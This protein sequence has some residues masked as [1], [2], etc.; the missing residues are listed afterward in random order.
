[1]LIDEFENILK[2]KPE[3][4][5]LYQR[6]KDIK[7]KTEPL[8]L[9][10]METFPEYTSHD[11]SHSERIFEKLTIIIPNSLIEQLNTYEIYFLA[12]S[13]YFHDIGMINF[14]EFWDLDEIYNPKVTKIQK[15]R[16]SIRENHHL[17]SEDFLIKNFKDFAIEDVHQAKIIGRICRGHRKEDLHDINLYKPD[18]I[19]QKYPINIPLLAAL[20][21]IGDELDITFERT[22]Q[23]IYDKVPIR[24]I[25]SND[26]WEKHL[27]ISGVGLNPDNPLI[28][29]CNANCKNPKIHRALKGLETKINNQ[30]NDLVN[31]LHQY[32]SCRKDIPRTFL[33]DIE[34]ED[35]TPYDFKFSLQEKEIINLLMGEKLY[36]RKEESIRELLKNSVDACRLRKDLFKKSRLPFSPIV[37]FELTIDEN[38]LIVTDNGIGMDKDIIERYFTKI[39]QSFYR[40]Q[41]FLEMGIDFSPVNELG[42]GILSCFMI[43]N[44]IVVETKM[45]DSDPLIIEIDDVSDYF[46]VKKGNKKNTGTT[47]TLFLKENGTKIKL[48]R[49]IKLYARHLEF[50]IEVVLSNG[51]ECNIE[52]VGYKPIINDFGLK[53]EKYGFYSIKIN[54]DYFEG[55]LNF[56]LKRDE[57][58]GLI[59]MKP[60]RLPDKLIEIAEDRANT[61]I[62]YEGIYIGNI[63]ILPSFFSNK[64]MFI[65]LNVKKKALELNVARNDLVRN[66]TYEDFTSRIEDILFENLLDF[67]GKLEKKSMRKNMDFAKFSR[68]FIDNY[69]SY[70]F[71]RSNEKPTGKCFIFLQKFLRFK[72]VS[73]HGISYLSNNEIIKSG[74]DIIHLSGIP[75]ISND[76]IKQIFSECA[77]FSENFLYLQN[78]YLIDY[79]IDYL[80]INVNRTDFLTFLEM[81]KSKEL[82]GILPTRWKLVKF[83]TYKTSRFIEFVYWD[84]T[85]VNRDNRF[86]D[87]LIKNKHI[88]KGGKKIAILGFF[89]SLRTDLNSDFNIV[90]SK[91]RDILKLFIDE[92]LITED[93]ICNYILT[94][95][96]FP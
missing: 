1:M 26:E 12:S 95:D 61:F 5:A 19:Y 25:I 17:R 37:E 29:K 87:F 68:D 35:Y 94:L 62:S 71:R 84:K 8:L 13:V 64:R 76:H 48:D 30:L 57:K 73:K 49:E 40:S 65:D 24:D 86:I 28:I 47:I 81:E 53:A 92:Q 77:G 58:I 22:P 2:L 80:L 18:R 51:K 67:F 38:K 89:R 10:I 9:K 14:P 6:L 36:K 63:N 96:D 45:D 3:G 55:I 4:E 31:H 44:R 21:R 93:E 23:I 79:F 70:G 66:E 74:K 32:R 11:I 88:I 91:Q 34:S 52:D 78:D 42:I 46:F 59:P 82:K 20:L 60:G 72:S 75:Q 7:R 50:P 83:K 41:E 54:D 69:C 15:V 33:M 90:T 43:A 85:F 56:I 27:S 16:E 39:G